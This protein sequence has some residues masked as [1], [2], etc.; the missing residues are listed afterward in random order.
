MKK[1]LNFLTCLILLN[2][3]QNKEKVK[4]LKE[5]NNTT[6]SVKNFSSD[7]NQ[8]IKDTEN[9]KEWL[10]ETIETYFKKDLPEMRGITTISY[11]EYKT[12]AT[13][14]DLDPEGALTQTEFENKWKRLYDPKY[15][16]I[17]NGFLISGQDWGKIEVTKC[18]A[19]KSNFK[20]KFVFVFETT[21][22]DIDF[23]VDYKREI[24]VIKTENSFLICDVK[25]YD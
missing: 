6:D 21:I 5:E 24:K 15:A 12:D 4:N 2:S 1:L 9:A 23:K 10:I 18:N 14:V 11:E 3:C 25:E 16:G 22:R 7:S 13:N 8:T 19:L 20:D 17:G